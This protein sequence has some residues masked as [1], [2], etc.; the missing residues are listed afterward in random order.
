MGFE[1]RE[2]KEYFKSCAKAVKESLLIMSML[3]EQIEFENDEPFEEVFDGYP[4]DKSFDEVVI[5]FIFWI[6]KWGF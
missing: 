2:R 6:E 4:F 5:D 1:N 3:W